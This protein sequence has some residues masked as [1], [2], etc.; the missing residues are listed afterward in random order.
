[1]KLMSIRNIYNIIIVI[2]VFVL[3]NGCQKPRPAG[4]ESSESKKGE[5]QVGS[6]YNPIELPADKEIVPAK[7]PVNGEL[8]RSGNL[9]I[10][11]DTQ[12]D[13]NIITSNINI[14]SAFDTANSQAFRIQILTSK[15]YGDVRR[16]KMVAEEIFDRPVYLDYEVPYYKIR[17]GSF[18]DRDNAE[19]YLQQV[20]MAGYNDAWVVVTNVAVKSL[21][22]L[23][24]DKPLPVI[25]D[26]LSEE[27]QNIESDNTIEK[28][29]T[30]E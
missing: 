18:A 16:A 28:T 15:V 11:G 30:D 21:S 9:I 3:L 1:M 17:V 12:S 23:Y 7:Y 29:V 14:T 5:E 4:E 24:D 6:R 27:F 8:I 2:S 13:D 20:R 25:I 22:P 10:S 26:S 19:D